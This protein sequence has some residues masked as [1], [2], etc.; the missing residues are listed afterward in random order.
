IDETTATPAPTPTPLPTPTPTPAPTPYPGLVDPASVGQPYGGEVAGLLTFRGNPTRTYYGRGP[1]P[2]DPT[3]QWSYPESGTMCGLSSVASEITTWCGTGWTGQPAIFERGDK[4]WTVFGAYD[5]GVH[6]VDADTGGTLLEPFLTGDII[7]GS[8]TIDPDGFPLVYSGSRDD[9][10][11]ILATDRDEPV[12]LWRLGADDIPGARWN[13]DWDGSALVLDDYLFEGG[14]NSVFHIVKLNRG[15]DDEG[16]VT[17][18]PELVFTAPGYDDELISAVGANVSIENSVV[19]IGETV[20]FANSGG[21][22]QGWDVSGLA[23]GVEPERVFRYWTGDDV[24]ATLVAD[25]EGFLYVGVEYE[26]ANQRSAEVGQLIKLDPSSDDPLVWSIF[27]NNNLP[28]GF[29][30]TPAIYRD[31]VIAASNSG[32]LIGADRAT[33]EIRWEVPLPFGMWSSPVIVD[34]VLLQGDC[35]GTLHAFDVSDTTVQPPELWSV[36][37]G[38]C[39]E[40]TP[41]VWDGRIILGTRGGQVHM[42]SD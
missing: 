4:T 25:A 37:L 30:A 28:D 11:H 16:L 14:E 21:L 13:N 1:V 5:Y 7:K 31:L 23:D 29:W 8:V 18:D 33:G 2:K 26:R 40:S 15:Y 36:D 17:V 38:A 10:F 22:V 6:F 9:Y 20:Y 32:R 27:D 42:L 34:D 41:A 19:V 35:N 3:V 24:D 12:E 39:I